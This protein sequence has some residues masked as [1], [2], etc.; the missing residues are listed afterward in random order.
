MKSVTDINI[1]DNGVMCVN[2]FIVL[3]FFA[4][5]ESFLQLSRTEVKK[6]LADLPVASLGW[7]ADE[8]DSA[9]PP[10]SLSVG[11]ALPRHPGL[12]DAETGAAA[13]PH[14]PSPLHPASP[15]DIEPKRRQGKVIHVCLFF[16]R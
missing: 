6:I 10:E 1:Q 13:A 3:V 4:S 12:S 5:G 9:A 8:Y 14:S 2:V 16:Y 7:S 15:A 11:P